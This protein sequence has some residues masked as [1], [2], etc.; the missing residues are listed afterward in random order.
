M[1]G[2]ISIHRKIKDHWIWKSDR[3]LKW[4][5]DI[6]LTVNHEDNKVLIKGTLIDCKRGQSIRS[7]ESWGREWNVT[8]KAVKDFFRLL[9]REQMLTSESLQI[10]TRIT[11]CKWEDYQDPSIRNGNAKE[12]ERKRNGNAKVTQTI[13]N[14]ND[15][16]DNKNIPLPLKGE[17][18]EVDLFLEKVEGEWRP[19]VKYWIDYKS[20][21]GQS[22]R[23]LISMKT[24]YKKLLKISDYNLSEA[25][26]IVEKSIAAN[27]PVFYELKSAT[28]KSKGY[29]YGEMTLLLN[30]TVKMEDFDRVMENG[31]PRY[32]RKQLQTAQ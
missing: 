22:Y 23:G 7:L 32:Y 4:W 8:K 16:N 19:I 15:N 9:E 29:S 20:E 13:M 2:W 10:T 3:R 27:S 24:M 17:I 28:Q 1:E 31:E 14:N 18:G 11:V 25:K 5:L 6:L 30:S 12:T 26:A 21:K